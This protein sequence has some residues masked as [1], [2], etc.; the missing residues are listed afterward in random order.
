ML[1][2]D[3]L[4]EY[5]V[6]VSEYVPVPAII[7]NMGIL[8]YSEFIYLKNNSSS[9]SEDEMNN[10]VAEKIILKNYLGDDYVNYVQAQKGKIKLYILAD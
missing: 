10:L 3:A 8:N 5:K 2:V 9:L 4:E 1:K 6:K 7:S